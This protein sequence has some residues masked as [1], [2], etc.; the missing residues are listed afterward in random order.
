MC[1]GYSKNPKLNFVVTI[2]FYYC[3]HC[4]IVNNIMALPHLL[5]LKPHL[6]FST[7]LLLLLLLLTIFGC[8]QRLSPFSGEIV[9]IISVTIIAI[10]KIFK[11]VSN[12]VSN[13]YKSLS[14]NITFFS[15]I[16]FVQ[17]ST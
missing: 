14:I 16:P 1:S 10:S 12:I 4:P 15:T 8:L 9:S 7:F 11:R 5:N 2:K 6:P 13:L 3:Y 17:L